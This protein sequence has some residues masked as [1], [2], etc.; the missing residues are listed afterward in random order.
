MTIFNVSSN[1]AKSRQEYI[2]VSTDTKP[3]TN[4]PT[5]STFFEGDSGKTYIWTANSTSGS[6]SDWSLSSN[7]NDSVFTPSS[8]SSFKVATTN[9][10]GQS[11]TVVSGAKKL[12]VQ[13]LDATNFGLISFGN[14]ATLAETNANNNLGLVIE[15]GT[16]EIF[17]IPKA[18]TH[19]A[20]T[21]NTASITLNITQGI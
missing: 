14:N 3:T 1:S 6:S 18:A 7:P 17:G 16:G 21:A 9:P 19:Y 15:A 5:G 10:S 11:E 13:N 4:V 8:Y 12:R 2:G 20:W